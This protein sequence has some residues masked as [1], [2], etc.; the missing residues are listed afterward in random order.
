MVTKKPDPKKAVSDV[1]EK[2]TKAFA[3]VTNEVTNLEKKIMGLPID[4]RTV[5]FCGLAII[6]F[7]LLKTMGTVLLILLGIMMMYLSL[8]KKSVADILNLETPKKK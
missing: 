4:R 7:S 8:T 3:S 1:T 5:F 6:V 2:G